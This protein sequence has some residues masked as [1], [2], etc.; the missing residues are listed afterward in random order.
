M[1]GMLFTKQGFTPLSHLDNSLLNKN[2]LENTQRI[3]IGEDYVYA[4][5]SVALSEYSAYTPFYHK[6][7]RLFILGLPSASHLLN[8][9]QGTLKREVSVDLLFDRFRNV[10]LSSQN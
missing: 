1:I 8:L 6:F 10:L 2:Q 5:S 3:D 4:R 9:Q 7:P